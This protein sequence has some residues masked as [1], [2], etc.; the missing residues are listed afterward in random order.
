M[1]RRKWFNMSWDEKIFSIVIYFILFI[2]FSIT[3]YPLVYVASMSVSDPTAVINNEVK[4]F[5]VGFSLKSYKMLLANPDVLIGFANTVYYTV[6]GTLYSTAVTVLAAYVLSRKDFILRSFF[7][8]YFMIPMYIGGGMVPSFLLI[9]KLGL[10]DTRAAIILPGALSTFTLV[11]AITYFKDFPET[12]VEAAKIDGYNAIQIFSKVVIPTS[13]PIMAVVVL[14]YAVDRW[15][16]YFNSVLYLRTPSKQPLTVFLAKVLSSNTNSMMFG[17]SSDLVERSS[18]ALQMRYS[19]IM[20]TIIPIMM[21]YPF[22]Q[23]YLIQGVMLG[24]LK[25]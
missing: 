10:Y 15:N 1:R 6:L 19:L 2:A 14:F 9:K 11:I 8:K 13:K 21:V 5:P 25:E 3:L 24:S 4:L 23:K 12:L 20:I 17:D 18:M 16:A 7:T 22:A